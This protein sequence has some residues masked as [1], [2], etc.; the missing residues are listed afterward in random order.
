MAR[1]AAAPL[2]QTQLAEAEARSLAAEA[3]LLAMLVL[4]TKP[5]GNSKGKTGKTKR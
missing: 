2:S 3:E 4:D 1:A 5:A